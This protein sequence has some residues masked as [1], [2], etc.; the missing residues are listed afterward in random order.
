MSSHLTK[1]ERESI[2]FNHLKG[3]KTP[4]YNVIEHPNGKYT[5]K[6]IPIEMEEE[7]IDEDTDE[8]TEEQIEEEEVIDKKP[9]RVFKSRTKQNARK[10]LEQLTRIMD[11]DSEDDNDNDND[12]NKNEYEESTGQYIQKIYKP[13][14]QNWN[15]R[16]LV[17]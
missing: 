12:N 16:R 8:D 5:V 15:R 1:S 6:P 7:D 11:E 14:P 4:G 13:G 9:H 2:I 10:L 3:K 17:F